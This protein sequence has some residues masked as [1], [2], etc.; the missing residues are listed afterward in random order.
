MFINH[1]SDNWRMKMLLENTRAILGNT[2][3]PWSGKTDI[4]WQ[5]MIMPHVF[6]TLLSWNKEENQSGLHL[7][8]SLPAD[9]Y[10]LNIGIFIDLHKRLKHWQLQLISYESNR[11]SIKPFKRKEKKTKSLRLE[12]KSF[13]NTVFHWG[14]V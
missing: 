5:P 11:R 9:Q 2:D 4:H 13:G 14:N 10:K 12:R 1:T 8:C 3:R 7:V 6:S